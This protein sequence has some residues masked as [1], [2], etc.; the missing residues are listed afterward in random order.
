MKE[1]EWDNEEVFGG[2]SSTRHYAEVRVRGKQAEGIYGKDNRD[3]EEL[4]S[5][6]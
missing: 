1:P 4:K 5:H 2:T 6:K 3:S